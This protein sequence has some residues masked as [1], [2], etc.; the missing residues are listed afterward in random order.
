MDP[1]LKLCMIAGERSGDLHASSV[2]S[3]IRRTLPAAEIFGMGGKRMKEAG[4]QVIHDMTEI[5]VV[6]FLEVL[7]NIRTFRR[8]FHDLLRVI[9]ERKPDAV[10]LVDLP[11]F[12][13]RF[14]P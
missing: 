3:S 12:N 10:M 8:I 5:A 11:G 6:G 1:H 7:R 13:L 14:G 2:A 4:V 9:E